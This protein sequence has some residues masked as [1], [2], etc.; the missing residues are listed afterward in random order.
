MTPPTAPQVPHRLDPD[1]PFARGFVGVG[2]GIDVHNDQ[3][4]WRRLL[5]E[6]SKG[7][8]R[9]PF[10]FFEVYTRGDVEGARAVRKAAGD[11]PLLYHDDDLDPILPGSPRDAALAAAQENVAAVGAPWCVSELATRRVG[12][13][14]LDFFMPILL[15]EEAARVAAESLRRIDAALPGRLVAEN[16]PYQLPV[17][18]LHVL[19]L[20]ART[21]DLADAPCVLDLGHLYSFQLCKG[22]GPLAGLDGFPMERVIE[23]HV[24][25][26]E[27]DRRWGPALYRDAHGAADIAPEVLEMLGQLAPRCPNLR[28]VTIEVEEATVERVKQQLEQTR[29]AVRPLLERRAVAPATSTSPARAG[30]GR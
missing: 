29:A 6:R 26:A 2:V 30:G 28:A 9:M 12:E 24:A 22:L 1:S 20:M 17:G 23:L 14:Y 16:P 19:D 25:G 21:L 10:D 15:T 7:F 18:P 11:L 5:R 27:L 13:R 3:P 8:E 4:D